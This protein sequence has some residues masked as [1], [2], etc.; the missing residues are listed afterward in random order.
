MNT[1]KNPAKM[2]VITRSE[3]FGIQGILHGGQERLPEHFALA[4]KLK[5]RW[6]SSPTIMEAAEFYENFTV[7]DN[8]ISKETETDKVSQ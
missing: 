2:M 1:A 3:M 4:N 8:S 5:T 6:N 7:N